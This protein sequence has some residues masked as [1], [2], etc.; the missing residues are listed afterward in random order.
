[1][2]LSRLLFVGC[3]VLLCCLLQQPAA[4]QRGELG[5]VS[6]TCTPS[7][8]QDIEFGFLGTSTSHMSVNGV[9]NNGFAPFLSIDVVALNCSFPVETE[10]QGT[11]GNQVVDDECGFPSLLGS[12]SVNGAVF[13]SLTGQQL[14]SAGTELDCT[15]LASDPPPPF[16]G[17]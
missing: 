15:G 9:C 14:F 8:C 3:T 16:S 11:G 1:M 4:A 10:A 6:F 13:A 17:C 5:L 2:N 7:S 12:I